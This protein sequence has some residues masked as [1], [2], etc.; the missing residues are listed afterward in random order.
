MAH[1]GM[2]KK[3]LNTPDHIATYGRITKDEVGLRGMTAGRVHFDAGASW[4]ADLKPHAGTENRIPPHVAYVESGRLLVCRDDG[5][6]EEFGPGDIM[7]LPPG[8]DAWT[9]GDEPCRFIEFS[10]GN[11]Y[12]ER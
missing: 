11:D 2:Q 4:S 6:Q 3:N 7:M 12:Y 9:I 8:H 1:P 5:S 10:M